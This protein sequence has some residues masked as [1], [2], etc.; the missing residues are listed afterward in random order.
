MQQ[1]TSAV[2]APLTRFSLNKQTDTDTIILV[3]YTA[4]HCS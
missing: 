3:L 4:A 1:V 2:C